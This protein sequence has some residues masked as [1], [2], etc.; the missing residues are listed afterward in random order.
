MRNLRRIMQ[1]FVVG[2]RY[3]KRRSGKRVVK[4]LN[5]GMNLEKN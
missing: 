2:A 3:A 4:K 1:L 5:G